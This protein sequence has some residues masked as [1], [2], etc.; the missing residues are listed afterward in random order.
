MS[1]ARN[2]SALCAVHT[3]PGLI[4]H[5]TKPGQVVTWNMAG[6]VAVAEG[7]SITVLVSLHRTPFQ[8]QFPINLG[9]LL[10][11]PFTPPPT[12]FAKLANKSRP[13][14]P[15]TAIVV[16]EGTEE[17]PSIPP[18]FDR[19]PC[20]KGRFSVE[21]PRDPKLHAEVSQLLLDLGKQPTD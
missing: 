18:E 3:V 12:A 7:S 16:D 17:A 1:D 10:Q 8:V 21:T 20:W 5:W 2:A 9:Y 15:A 4:S 11:T 14:P 13:P 19:I 6:Q